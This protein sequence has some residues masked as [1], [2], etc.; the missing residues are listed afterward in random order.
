ML[1]LLLLVCML[2]A[3]PAVAIITPSGAAYD[4]V[5]V[6]D[7]G[8]VASVETADVTCVIRANENLAKI[9]SINAIVQPGPVG[10]LAVDIR[11]VRQNSFSVNSAA[12]MVTGT[13]SG[14]TEVERIGIGNLKG[15]TPA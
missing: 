3:F 14:F 5:A 15:S 11:S 6:V 4:G 8:A 7:M 10:G 1:R 2:L 13:I 12:R 9:P